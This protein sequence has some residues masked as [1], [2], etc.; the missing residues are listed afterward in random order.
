MLDLISNL[1]NSTNM[2]DK[3]HD[4]TN[5]IKY[6]VVFSS[7]S[8][9][10]NS[11]MI[12]VAT[13]QKVKQEVVLSIGLSVFITLTCIGLGIGYNKD[14]E[15]LNRRNLT[16]YDDGISNFAEITRVFHQQLEERVE[17]F[18]A[19]EGT[20]GF[21][22]Q[23]KSG[24]YDDVLNGSSSNN[25][26]K[27]APELSLPKDQSNVGSQ[28]LKEDHNVDTDPF[29]KQ[30]EEDMDSFNEDNTKQGCSLTDVQECKE[31]HKRQIT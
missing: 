15:E 28:V 25:I 18:S 19:K 30:F 21:E 23:I 14:Q 11:V 24:K 27:K 8:L 10:I 22:E 4:F 16:S 17:P 31:V 29:S 1:T 3:K 9:L 12:S 26:V 2:K 6:G 5:I 7:I 20:A 13:T